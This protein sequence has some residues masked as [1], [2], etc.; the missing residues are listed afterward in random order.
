MIMNFDK[1][2]K[3]NLITGSII[4][5]C[6]LL[7]TT[8]ASWMSI[9]RLLDSQQW[10]GHTHEVILS[11]ENIMSKTKDAETGQR[12]YLLTGQGDFLEPYNG[13]KEEVWKSFEKVSSL[14]IDNP[15]QQKDLD[16]LSSLIEKRFELLQISVERK[17]QGLPI[18]AG[19]IE[20]GR[21]I[22]KDLRSLI[23]RMEGREQLLL[24]GRT[25]RLSMFSSFTPWLIIFASLVAVVVTITFYL[26][27]KKDYS[28]KLFMQEQLLEKEK[29]IKK[30]ID[31]VQRFAEEVAKGD[32]SQR[33]DPKDLN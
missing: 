30:K 11:I 10:V 25:E 14:T 5:L 1:K 13:A 3:R 31:T 18:V 15:S 12:G 2:Y 6:I 24:K 17:R 22:M 26:R 8:F 16:Y 23:S 20:K 4:S 33:I 32:Y 27:L 19:N 7:I 29:Q 9:E 21:F 28:Q